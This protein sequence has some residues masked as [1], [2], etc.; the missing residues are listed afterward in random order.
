MQRLTQ[1]IDYKSWLRKLDKLSGKWLRRGQS[2]NKLW[3]KIVL[4]GL[5]LSYDYSY[6]FMI[7]YD[8]F[9]ADN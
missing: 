5:D 9:I 7:L 1:K 8:G 4:I 6:D 2:W 3:Y